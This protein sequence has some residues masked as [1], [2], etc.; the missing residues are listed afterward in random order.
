MK[1]L[2]IGSNSFSGSHFVK[3][4]LE[5][6]HHVIG[7]SRSQNINP[8][9]LPYKWEVNDKNK[10][11]K[12]IQKFKFYKI[13]LNKNFDKLINLIDEEK[14]ELIFNFAAQGMVAESWKNPNHWYQT[15]LLSQVRLHENLRKKTFLKKYIHITTPEVYGSTNNE[16]IKE[17][18]NFKPSTP[19][20]ISR[21]ACDLHLRSFY[22]AYDF[23]VIF[24]RAA[25]VY[26][27]GQQLYRIIPR[28]ILS[29]ITGEP[30]YLHGEG[31][32]IRSFIY[33]NDVV[34]ATLNLG[35]NADIGTTWHISTKKALSIK[36]LV[37]K[38]CEIT[39]V[40]YNEIV[41]KSS[42]RLGK[43]Q[44]YLLNS[45]SIRETFNWEDKV[46]LN[47]GIINTINWVKKH[48]KT[49]KMLSWE[50]QHKE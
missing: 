31:E 32:S 46:D 41:K 34:E 3:H 36:D 28:T 11:L 29:C 39:N 17:N 25:N 22:E 4:A 49:L 1:I 35:I 38:I 48:L 30:F 13:D 45:E 21:A 15:N 5:N 33:I 47:D 40:N 2:V 14:P 19:Y 6:N 16:W 10:T 44:T 9:F 50:Y 26:G 18:N 12:F 27:P 8:I 43:D 23:P 7:I 24:T 37:L 42:D 20:A